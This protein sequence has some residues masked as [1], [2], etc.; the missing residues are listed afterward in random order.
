M[1]TMPKHVDSNKQIH[2]IWNCG[3]D[4]IKNMFI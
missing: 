4:D 3:F 2:R 1:A